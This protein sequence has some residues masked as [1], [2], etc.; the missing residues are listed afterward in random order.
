MNIEQAKTEAPFVKYYHESLF[1]NSIRFMSTPFLKQLAKR[2][3][4]ELE[5]RGIL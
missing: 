5:R 1:M 2:I 4:L 3:S